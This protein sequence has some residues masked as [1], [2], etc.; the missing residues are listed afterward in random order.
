MYISSRDAK[1]C[2]STARRLTSEGPGECVSIPADLSK[3]EEC[4][5]LVKELGKRESR[6]S[7]LSPATPLCP[8]CRRGETGETTD[9][10]RPGY[11]GEQHGRHLGRGA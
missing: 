10:R 2:D 9:A 1:A 8:L 7:F 11:P 6:T 4:E 3:L 5:R